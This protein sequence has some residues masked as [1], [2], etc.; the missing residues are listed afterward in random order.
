MAP[1]ADHRL[2]LWPRTAVACGLMVG[3]GL[4][5]AVT[6]SPRL[7]LALAA[8]GGAAMLGGQPALAE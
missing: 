3:T 4:A 2:A 5:V 6:G 7:G 8:L 1:A